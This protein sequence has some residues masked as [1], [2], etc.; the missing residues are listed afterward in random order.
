MLAVNSRSKE[1]EEPLV[2][3]DVVEVIANSFNLLVAVRCAVA[4]LFST[5][6]S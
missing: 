5:G 4:K 2:D 6:E 1:T 3:E